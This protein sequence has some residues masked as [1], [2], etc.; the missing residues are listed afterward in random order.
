MIDAERPVYVVAGGP[1]LRGFDWRRLDGRQVVAINRAYEVL[2]DAAMLWW[3]DAGFWR[4]NRQ[5]IHAHRA[6]LK[7][8]VALPEDRF[9]Y[10]L[11]VTI[12]RATGVDG[13]DGTTGAI[14]HGCNSG[15]AA[16]HA[17]AGLGARRIV[18]MGLDMRH[19]GA[20]T[21][22][23]TGHGMLHVE[24][25]LRDRML[26]HFASLAAALSARGVE[27]VNASPASLV[28]CWPKAALDDVL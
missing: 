16:I 19:E 4:R 26:P 1:S 15:Y 10:P 20:M 17:A 2:P 21:H 8:T 9:A 24:R 7:A 23:H 3:S 22:W 11:D 14:R 13:F 18:V 25:T 28:D 27:V 12:Y 6:P 5:P